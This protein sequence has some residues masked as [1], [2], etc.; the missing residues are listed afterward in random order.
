IRH[1]NLLGIMGEFDGSDGVLR[2]K[3]NFNGSI[4][5]KVG[6]FTY[7]PSPLKAKL[8]QGLKKIIGR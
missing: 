8:L 5:Q 2:F 6:T 1:Y 7:F 4:S 3:Q